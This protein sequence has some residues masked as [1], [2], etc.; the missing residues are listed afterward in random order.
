[1]RYYEK[2]GIRIMEV[3]AKDFRVILT[4]EK[5]KSMG[6]NRCNAGFFGPFKEGAERFTLP[7]GH[8]V[9]DFSATSEIT[10]H[11]CEERGKFN[12]GKFRFDS[13]AWGQVNVNP[14]HG[15][16]VTTLVVADG[17]ATVSDLT[18][19]P[20]CDYAIA[21][22]P[23]VRGWEDVKYD[24]Y[25]KGQGWDVS[26]LRATWH[27]FVGIKSVTDNKVFVMA[28][29]TTSG[30][31]VLS[32]EAFRKFK[33]LGF[34][35]VIKLDGGGSTYFNAA[36]NVVSTLENRRICTI[37]DCGGNPWPVPTRT[38]KQGRKGDDVRWLQWELTA[39]GFPCELSLIHI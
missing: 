33:A 5:K 10:R 21:G 14:L 9:A 8:L 22:I 36:G 37:I 2:N 25:V 11:Y 23:I 24:P 20:A 32:A 26:S 27:I 17:W 6:R 4:D 3:P 7:V 38:L 30:N 31:M 19:V 39:Q 35:D 15:K 16:A 18:A 13:C 28:A 34:R 1:M 29:K 12:G